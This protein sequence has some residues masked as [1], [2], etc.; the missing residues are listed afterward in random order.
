MTW[1]IIRGVIYPLLFDQSSICRLPCHWNRFK[2][3]GPFVLGKTGGTNKNQKWVTKWSFASWVVN[4][5]HHSMPQLTLWT[6][7]WVSTQGETQRNSRSCSVSAA[8]CLVSCV[9]DVVC[10]KV[11]KIDQNQLQLILK[12]HEPVT[13]MSSAVDHES[14]RLVQM[15]TGCCLGH[16]QNSWLRAIF[17]CKQQHMTAGGLRVAQKNLIKLIH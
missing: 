6:L 5:T 14:S 9:C 16:E 7:A 13:Q 3:T 11:K 1:K 15:S 10:S 2:S 12:W 4:Y 17:Q 8:W